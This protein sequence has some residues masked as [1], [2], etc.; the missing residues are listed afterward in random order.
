MTIETVAETFS[1]LLKLAEVEDFDA[2]DELMTSFS[3]ALK[4]TEKRAEHLVDDFQFDKEFG[5][6]DLAAAKSAL[7]N[8]NV[9]LL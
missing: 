2:Y 5:K 6:S 1:K 4:I 3:N 9:Q 7:E 8:R